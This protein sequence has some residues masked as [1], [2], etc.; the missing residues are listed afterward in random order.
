MRLILI[1]L[2]LT[3]VN[4]QLISEGC[5]VSLKPIRFGLRFKLLNMLCKPTQNAL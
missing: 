2:K 5:Q 3:G 4:G 1:L